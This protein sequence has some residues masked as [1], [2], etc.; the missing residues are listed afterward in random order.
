MRVG[1]YK[2]RMTGLQSECTGHRTVKSLDTYQRVRDAQKEI[3]SDVLQRSA[4]TVIGIAALNSISK[5]RIAIQFFEFDGKG[6]PF[7]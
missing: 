3:V 6:K 7:H 4:L 5:F 1:R 2:F